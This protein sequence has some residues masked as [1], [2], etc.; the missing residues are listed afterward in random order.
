MGWTAAAGAVPIARYLG[1]Y[2]QGAGNFDNGDSWIVKSASTP[3]GVAFVKVLA[4]TCTEVFA[5]YHFP[6]DSTSIVRIRLDS[7]GPAMPPD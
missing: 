5:D 3:T 1:D 4:I 2:T 6:D 7:L